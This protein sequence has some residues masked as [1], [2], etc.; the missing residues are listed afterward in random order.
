MATK[1]INKI[2][3]TDM[4]V[5]DSRVEEYRKLGFKLAKDV[6]PV[7]KPEITEDAKAVK[8]TVEHLL[9]VPKPTKAGSG[10]KTTR[11]R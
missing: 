8:E 9:E 10:K 6:V 7:T 2:T 3:G 4:W 11:K 5:D 1:F